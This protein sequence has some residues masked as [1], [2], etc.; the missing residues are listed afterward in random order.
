MAEPNGMCF[1]IGYDGRLY[2]TPQQ[3]SEGDM[4]LIVVGAGTATPDSVA[5]LFYQNGALPLPWVP[6][7]RFT[8]NYASLLA[9]P[10]VGVV[11]ATAY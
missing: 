2:F 7:A 6:S 9:P 11:R 4:T 1:R 8:L 5:T 3:M 10:L